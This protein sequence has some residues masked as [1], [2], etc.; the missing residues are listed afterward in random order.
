[1]GP[2]WRTL[3]LP[4]PRNA[5]RNGISTHTCFVCFPPAPCVWWQRRWTAGR[6]AGLVLQLGAVWLRGGWRAVGLGWWDRMTGMGLLTLDA[7][8]SAGAWH[9]WMSRCF[10]VEWWYGLGWLGVDWMWLILVFLERGGSGWLGLGWA[11]VDWIGL[12][13]TRPG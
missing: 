4:L 6:A 1:M 8:Q 9:R 10:G 7:F 13:W 12:A 5:R 3:P 11:E 2:C